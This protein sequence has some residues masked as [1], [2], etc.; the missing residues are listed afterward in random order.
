[1][2]ETFS[3]KKDSKGAFFAFSHIVI[4]LHF[5]FTFAGQLQTANIQAKDRDTS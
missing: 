5:I 4:S 3:L 2:S 1:M